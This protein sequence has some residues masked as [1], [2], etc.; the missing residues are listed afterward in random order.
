M[1]VIYKGARDDFLTYSDFNPSDWLDNE[2]E[3]Q[4]YTKLLD[5]FLEQY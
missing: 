4:E 3:K 1:K 5:L 2:E